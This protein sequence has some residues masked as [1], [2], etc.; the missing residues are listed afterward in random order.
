[1]T[2]RRSLRSTSTK[3]GNSFD[4]LRQ[5]NHYKES[6]DGQV[7]L[8]PAVAAGQRAGSADDWLVITAGFSI[9][10][11]IESAAPV[12][13]FLLLRCQRLADRDR[14]TTH[15]WV[16]LRD[17]AVGGALSGAVGQ[18]RWS[19][20]AAVRRGRGPHSRTVSM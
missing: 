15:R 14:S 3:P 17:A 4:R 20:V 7:P 2:V 12:P 5:A 9:D 19:K 16:G 6:L 1:M 11:V 18:S 8:T 13:T 10:R